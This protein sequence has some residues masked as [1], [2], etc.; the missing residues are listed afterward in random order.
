MK[1]LNAKN[2]SST[3]SFIFHLLIFLIIIFSFHNK[4]ENQTSKYVEIGFAGTVESNSPGSPGIDINKR[5]K[6]IKHEKVIK[7]NSIKRNAEVSKKSKAEKK[8]LS[9]A[10]PNDSAAG[11]NNTNQNL[12]A[13]NSDS[14]SGNGN[15]QNGS[16]PA[17][18][19]SPDQEDFYHVAVDQMPVPIGGIEEID[20]KAYYPSQAKANKIEGTVYVLAFIDENGFVRKTSLIKGIGYGCDQSAMRAVKETRFSPGMLHGIPVKVQLTVPVKFSLH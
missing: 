20:T 9:N 1:L 15:G 11:S 3:I 6:I 10:S 8:P 14:T 17:K 12:S 16:G 5:P 13:N 2:F 4:V 19:G 18:K 7:K